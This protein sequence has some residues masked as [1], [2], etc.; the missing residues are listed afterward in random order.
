MRKNGHYIQVKVTPEEKARF[1]RIAKACRLT[2]KATLMKMLAG[3]ELREYPP[4]GFDDVFYQ[5]GKIGVNAAFL[6]NGCLSEESRS[7]IFRRYHA[8]DQYVQ[9]VKRAMLYIAVFGID[10][11]PKD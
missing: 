1:V 10:N 2:E 6:P 8:F 7:V 5:V 3:D 4:A 11:E 9:L